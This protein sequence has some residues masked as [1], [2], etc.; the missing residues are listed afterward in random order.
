M[1]LLPL[2]QCSLHR[3]QDG[4]VV[5]YLVDG[6][7][8]EGVKD[9]DV[10]GPDL[11]Q[12]VTFSMRHSAFSECMGESCSDHLVVNLRQLPIHVSSYDDLGLPILP[13]DAFHEADDCLR[14]LHHEAFL[15]WFQV[16]VEDVDLL[17]A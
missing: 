5:R 17:P 13:D 6:L 11:V 7:G 14:S 12:M 4:A 3:H 2:Y 9:G 16:H 8:H 10:P 15:P 1:Y